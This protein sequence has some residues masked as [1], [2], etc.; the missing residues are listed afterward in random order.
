MQA[1]DMV[2]FWVI[3]VVAFFILGGINFIIVDGHTAHTLVEAAT[4][5][6]VIETS[7]S[8][9]GIAFKMDCHG[10]QRKAVDTIDN[11]KE[12]LAIFQSKNPKIAKCDIYANG[13]V[14]N[15]K[16]VE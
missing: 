14:S 12:V 16:P 2:P 8:A 11:G 7:A 9:H 3:W 4:S 6:N 13:A 15:C 10:E 1:R 5:C